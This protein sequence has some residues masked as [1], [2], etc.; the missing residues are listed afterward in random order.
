[1]NQLKTVA[2]LALLSALL[3]SLSYW[4]LGGWSGRKN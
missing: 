3:I 2:L 1:M 4:L